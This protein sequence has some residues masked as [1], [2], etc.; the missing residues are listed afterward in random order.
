MIKFPNHV[1]GEVMTEKFAAKSVTSLGKFGGHPWVEL[2]HQSKFTRIRI[3]EI[4]VSHRYSR[5]INP[6][7]DTNYRYKMQKPESSVISYQVRKLLRWISS[8]Y[9]I[10]LMISCRLFYMH[11]ISSKTSYVRS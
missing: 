6:L 4:K 3:L 8:L 10:L 2:N 5:V 7:V 1:Q 11:I 9:A